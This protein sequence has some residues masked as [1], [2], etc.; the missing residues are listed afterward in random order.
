MKLRIV[1]LLLV[2]AG[3][4]VAPVHAQSGVPRVPTAPIGDNFVLDELDWLTSEQESSI[5]GIIRGLDRD[6]VA[7]IG[8][9]TLN[10]CGTDKL[11]FRKELFDA[12]GIGHADD[13]DGLLILVCWYDGDLARRSVEQLYG[14]GLKWAL[15]ARKTDQIAQQDFVP[16]FRQ[17]KPGDG[18]TG[19][20]RDYNVLLRTTPETFF[21]SVFGY[22]QNLN[23]WLFLFLLL[24]FFTALVIVLERFFPKTSY[25][26]RDRLP[27]DRDNH[28]GDS[29]GGGFDG[30][31][32]DGGGGS[33][34]RF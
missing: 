10:D 12:W 29:D 28:W 14:P 30:G 26:N 21:S 31:H 4:I 15:D 18:L 11:A 8:V 24:A 7:Q 19:M 33:S 32:S 25:P 27:Y 16:A 3:L 1:P 34:T 9:V 2:V 6:G 5:N 13:D 23:D 20:V 22:L 17:G